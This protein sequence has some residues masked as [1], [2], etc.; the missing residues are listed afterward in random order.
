MLPNP[1]HRARRSAGPRSQISSPG[2]M[3]AMH[4]KSAAH[5]DRHELIGWG[6]HPF[7]GKPWSKALHQHHGH[8]LPQTQ[9]GYRLADIMQQR[10]RKKIAIAEPLLLQYTADMHPM[11]LLRARHTG[12]EREE[13][14]ASRAHLQPRPGILH[15]DRK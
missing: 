4:H 1:G 14:G 12:E 15:I 8:P 11:V 10:R 9:R 2:G 7:C 5:A 6:L 13:I 3:V